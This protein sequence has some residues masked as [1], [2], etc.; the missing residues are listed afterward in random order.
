MSGSIDA[1]MRLAILSLAVLIP[2]YAVIALTVAL[3]LARRLPCWPVLVAAAALLGAGVGAALLLVVEIRLNLIGTPLEWFT[4]AWILG[5]FTVLGVATANLYHS[6]V[7]RKAGAVLGAIVMV[8]A[9]ALVVNAHYGL[10]PTLGSLVGISTERPLALP[11]PSPQQLTHTSRP[12]VGPL[13]RTW[14]APAGMPPVGR[15]GSAEIPGV[16]S[17]FAARPAG[18]YLP[19]AALV[20]HPPALPLLVMMMGQPGNPDPQLVAATFD[21]FAAA[22]HGLA[23]IVIVADQ[24]S[25]PTV[26]TL[27]LDTARFGHVETYLNTDVVDW[28]RAHL[29]VL[30]DRAQWTIAGYSHGGQCAISFAAKHPDLWGNVLD[31]SGE[32]YP[33]AE[34]PRRT[35]LD[36]FSGD[37]AAYEAQRP[38]SLLT[39]R[40]YQ[41]TAAI[42]TVGMDDSTFRPGV[43]RVAAAA[44]SAGMQVSYRE[45]AHGG[46]LV[47]AL[48]GGL[49]QGAAE[50]YPRLGLSRP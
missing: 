3:L 14:S 8:A 25:N 49:E 45:I 6:R 30:L 33:G 16:V 13:W 40:Q 22:H 15:T 39:R 32:E 2:T 37:E 12:T 26:D 47:E 29:N 36:G 24:L 10:N 42:F 11:P 44:R 4:R 1:L 50:L 27:C 20:P 18:V 43:R 35:L 23:P 41:D 7:R 28:A 5:A 9:T 17:G 21:R 34:H 38:A 46:H 48:N 19:P 31:I